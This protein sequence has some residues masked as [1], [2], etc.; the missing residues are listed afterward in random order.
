M[1]ILILKTVVVVGGGG[2]VA[3]YIKDNNRLLIVRVEVAVLYTQ[4]ADNGLV[5]RGGH[6]RV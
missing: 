3:G 5:N 2:G 4:V 6:M 1:A